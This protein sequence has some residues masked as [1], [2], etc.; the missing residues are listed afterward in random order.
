ME[1]IERQKGNVVSETQKRITET[2]V[3]FD[4]TNIALIGNSAD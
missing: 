3:R 4:Q 1:K 2:A